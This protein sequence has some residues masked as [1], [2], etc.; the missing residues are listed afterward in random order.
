MRL[1]RRLSRA[2]RRQVAVAHCDVC[3]HHLTLVDP[4]PAAAV[5][6]RCPSGVVG[7]VWTIVEPPSGDALAAVAQQASA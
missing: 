3:G 2:S 6:H 4:H 1:V 7:P 5:E